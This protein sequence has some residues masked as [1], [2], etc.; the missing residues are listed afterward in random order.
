MTLTNC[1]V[2]FHP[3]WFCTRSVHFYWVFC[4]AH[5]ICEN[6]PFVWS[7]CRQLFAYWKTFYI[8]Y[9]I[10]PIYHSNKNRTG[11]YIHRRIH[12]FKVEIFA[13]KVHRFTNEIKFQYANIFSLIFCWEDNV[14]ILPNVMWLFSIKFTSIDYKIRQTIKVEIGR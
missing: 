10:R 6:I 13:L 3:F 2:S 8:Y 7:L 1:Y 11:V 9:I 12:V 14:E 5:L 4:F